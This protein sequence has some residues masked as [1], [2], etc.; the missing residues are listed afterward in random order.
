M[1]SLPDLSKPIYQANGVSFIPTT[2]SP[3]YATRRSTAAETLTEI[4]LADLGDTT[5]KTPYLIVRASHGRY[6]H[7]LTSVAPSIE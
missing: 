5:S 1:Y 6:H 7:R 4:L 3:D 2:I